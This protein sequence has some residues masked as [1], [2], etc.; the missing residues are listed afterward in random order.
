MCIR[1][2]LH[3]DLQS[4]KQRLPYGNRISAP[5]LSASRRKKGTYAVFGVLRLCADETPVKGNSWQAAG[6]F[7]YAMK[8]HQTLLTNDVKT[9]ILIEVEAQ[10]Q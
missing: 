4:E 3:G 1:D 6:L 9:S 10:K 7:F 8:W 5:G 2:R